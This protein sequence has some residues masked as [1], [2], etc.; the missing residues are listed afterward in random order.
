VD[1]REKQTPVAA[2]ERFGSR[3]LEPAEPFDFLAGLPIEDDKKFGKQLSTTSAPSGDQLA[4][5]M[6]PGS[7]SKDQANVASSSSF[8]GFSMTVRRAKKGNGNVSHALAELDAG[9]WEGLR[10]RENASGAV[11]KRAR[12]S[13]WWWVGARVRGVASGAATGGRRPHGWGP[14]TNTDIR[15]GLPPAAS[16]REPALPARVSGPSI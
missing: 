8:L 12:A 13:L 7:K 15:C 4:E 16:G 10:G 14:A 9:R 2:P 11:G 1:V 5:L 6:I 3:V